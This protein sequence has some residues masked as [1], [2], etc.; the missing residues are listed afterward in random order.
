MIFSRCYS[1]NG[2]MPVPFERI[3][4]DENAV[5]RAFPSSSEQ[6][7]VLALLAAGTQQIGWVGVDRDELVDWMERAKW[8]RV[9]TIVRNRLL[10]VLTLGLVPRFWKGTLSLVDT[11]GEDTDD[12]VNAAVL[13][14]R[15]RNC[16][17]LYGK[18]VTPLPELATRLARACEESE[19]PP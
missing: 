13:A 6:E 19:D 4:A 18:I 10:V 17:S 5:A 2:P 16:V 14:L 15:A 1:V 3:D 9:L 7:I 11:L 12:R 8:R